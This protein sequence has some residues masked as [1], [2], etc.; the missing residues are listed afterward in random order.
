MSHK[1]SFTVR[2]CMIGDHQGAIPQSAKRLQIIRSLLLLEILTQS[3]EI[4]I[5]FIAQGS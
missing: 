4:Q 5:P 3:A 1:G 2:F